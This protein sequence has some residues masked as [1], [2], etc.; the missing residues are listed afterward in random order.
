MIHFRDLPKSKRIH[1][2]PQRNITVCID[3]MFDIC[4]VCGQGYGIIQGSNKTIDVI[5]VFMLKVIVVDI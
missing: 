1:G 2:Y 5:F 4:I 3:V